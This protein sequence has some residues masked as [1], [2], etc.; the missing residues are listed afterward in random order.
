MRWRYLFP[1]LPFL[2][3][4]CVVASSDNAATS[5]SAQNGANESDAG[6]AATLGSTDPV[7]HLNVIAALGMEGRGTPS[8]GLDRAAAYVVAECHEGSRRWGLH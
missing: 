4:A 3:G 8:D 2:V 7:D 1:V 5:P 6:D